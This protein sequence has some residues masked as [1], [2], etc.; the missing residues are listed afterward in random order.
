MKSID[1]SG[2]GQI[3]KNEMLK[4]IE[5]GL[6]L[7]ESLKTEYAQRGEFHKT[8]IDFFQGRRSFKTIKIVEIRKNSRSRC[9]IVTRS[10]MAII[11]Y[12]GARQFRC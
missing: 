12:R 3:D 10:N 11:R 4:F 8:I 6:Q 1:G 7:S 2:D 9:R 5:E